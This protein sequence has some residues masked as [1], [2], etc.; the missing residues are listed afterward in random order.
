M[1]C[2]LAVGAVLF[3]LTFRLSALAGMPI[4]PTTTLQIETSNN[5]STAATFAAQSNGNAG[6]GNVSKLGVRT[7]LYSGATTKIYAHY[8]PWFGGGNHMDIGYDSDDP[9]QIKRQ[10]DD[11]MS[12]G[13]GGVIID[14][15]GQ[16]FTREN[17]SSR[18]MMQ[19]A[20]TRGGQFEFAIMEDG[21]QLSGC[22][23][24]PGCDVTLAAT[25]DLNYA[26]N[27]FEGSPAYMRRGGRPV[28]FFFDDSPPIDWTRL[29]ASVS[30]NPLFVFRNSTGFSHAKSN[31]AYSWVIPMS[32][33]SDISLGYLDDFY[34]NGL[35]NPSQLTFGSPYKGFNDTLAA[36]SANRIMNQSCGQ[37]WLSTMAEIGKF[38]SSGN[39]LGAIQLVTW[40]DYEEGTELESGVENCVTIS[41]ALTGSGF[42]LG[43]SITGQESTLDH[44]TVFI[45]SDG[46]NLMPLTDV[47]TGVHSLDL[48]SFA[49]DSGSY[50]LYVKAVG[51]PTLTNHM[52]GAVTYNTSGPLP[53][54]AKLSVTP[55]QGVAPLNVTA[56]T[57]GSSAPSGSIVSTTIDFGDGSTA[58]VPPAGSAAH[59][60]ASAGTYTVRATVK[61]NLGTTASASSPAAVAT[62]PSVT[63]TTT[64]SRRGFILPVIVVVQGFSTNPIT[65]MQLVLDGKPIGQSTTSSLRIVLHLH[66]RNATHKLSATAKDSS[67]ASFSATTTLTG[68]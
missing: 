64:G 16:N 58:T 50:I 38:Y 19:E 41:A 61:D 21:G 49:L 68:P 34:N 57:A 43:W 36:W 32:D 53:P 15:Y 65:H 54:V 46:Q 45:S 52:S 28:V 39:Q 55:A 4:V 31:G 3:A 47:A 12:R 14:W 35:G 6:A 60:Y 5:T 30:G 29:A 7:L 13:I 40:N 67:G 66:A 42:T 33:P 27:T 18:L 24:T 10:V 22:V 62:A 63:I 59:I 48:T 56:S 17:T 26:F 2:P 37:T 8:M 23:S 1:R 25:T 11:M 9:A 20:E 44:Y 51:K